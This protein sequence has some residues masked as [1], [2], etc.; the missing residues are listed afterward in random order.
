MVTGTFDPG[1]VTSMPTPIVVAVVPVA[2]G[3]GAVDLG[4]ARGRLPIDNAAHRLKVPVAVRRAGV[5]RGIGPYTPDPMPPADPARAYLDHAASTPPHPDVLAAVPGWL[6]DHG[7]N[8]TGM[9]TA[10]RAAKRALE[11]ARERIAAVLGC[12]PG[13][14]VITGGGTESDNLAV[15]GTVRAARQAGDPDRTVIAAFEHRAVLGAADRLAREGSEVALA[16]ATPSGTID[17]DRLAEL[18]DERVALVSVMTVNNE[19]GTRQPLAEVAALVRAHAPRARL[20]TDAVQACTWVDADAYAEADLVA[21]AGHKVGGLRGTGALVVRGGVHLLPEIEGGGQERDRRAGTP[22]VV[23]ALALALALEGTA[24][25]RP[26]EAT[27]I[28]GLRDRLLEGLFAE[29][30]DLVLHGASE[31][32]VAGFAPI[33]LPGCDSESL[34][35]L[36][37]LAGVD[38]SAGSSCASGATEPSHVL[39][40]MGV[41]PGTAKGALRL[42]LG[43]SSSDRDVDRVLEVLPGIVRQLRGGA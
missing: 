17:L 19:V 11:E 31:H 40:A 37:D 35:V 41:D 36:L 32:R 14:V 29:I 43:W 10:A 8:P 21:V 28:A 26:A 18:L 25:A 34:L 9:H 38:A 42:T 20:H 12:E 24:A 22:D 33:G 4:S 15:K 30:P 3:P 27:R 2:H 5:R 6:A 13:E 16:P 7:A 39:T 1:G 23:G